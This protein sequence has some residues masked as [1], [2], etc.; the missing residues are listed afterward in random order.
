MTTFY[1]YSEA[2][3]SITGYLS[4]HLPMVPYQYYTQPNSGDSYYGSVYD[5]HSTYDYDNYSGSFD[6]PPVFDDHEIDES[7][8]VEQP[9][10]SRQG[11][12]DRDGYYSEELLE[13]DH[14]SNRSVSEYENS[15]P[16]ENTTVEASKFKQYSHA[17]YPHIEKIRKFHDIESLLGCIEPNRLHNALYGPMLNI[18]E[19]ETDHVMAHQVPKKLLVLICGR[20]VISKYLRTR[21]RIQVAK[22][23]GAPVAQEL[24]I[25]RGAASHVGFK[26]L[27]S[28]MKR[29]CYWETMGTM[30]KIRVPKN[31]FAAI[32]L[33][34]VLDLFSLHRDA[35][36]VD[37]IIANFHLKRPIYPDELATVW[38]C[39]P[40]DSKY[41][42]G[43]INVLR[44]RLEAMEK[45]Q[46]KPLH[47]G[48]LSFLDENP[49]LN[50]RVRDP[51]I[52]RLYEPFFGTNW[53]KYIAPNQ[54]SQ[55]EKQQVRSERPRQRKCIEPGQDEPAETRLDVPKLSSRKK[56][57]SAM[58]KKKPLELEKMKFGVLRIVAPKS[59]MESVP[60]RDVEAM[61]KATAEGHEEEA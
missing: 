54:E 56:T 15:T 32:S 35:C 2:D 46:A 48:V 8:S 38:K 13:A 60:D 45:G 18:I 50:A 51:E 14:L 29:A 21:E 36:R 9:G 59:K 53:C 6:S 37:H 30:E 61:P 19:E 23:H 25:P 20:A 16:A 4:Q 42:F 10:S 43:V 49:D 28:W 1:Q 40:K 41:V 27:I 3:G 34:R 31:L 44:T 12:S 39:L 52:N 7:Q 55:T 17:S 24:C 33:A 26:V 58:E 22:G 57:M 47:E 5:T 11:Q